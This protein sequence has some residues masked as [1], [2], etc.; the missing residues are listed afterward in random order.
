MASSAIDDPY[1]NSGG[2]MDGNIGDRLIESGMYTTVKIVN[3]AVGGTLL[4][5]WLSTAPNNCYYPKHNDDHFTYTNYRLYERIQFAVNTANTLGFSFTHVILNIGESN[6]GAGTSSADYSRYLTQFRDDLRNLGVNAPIFISKTSYLPGTSAGNMSNITTAQ[7][8]IINS[9]NDVFAGP[10]TDSRDSSYRWDNVHFNDQGLN[11]LGQLWGY[12]LITPSKTFLTTSSS[13]TASGLKRSI[14]SELGLGDYNQIS[15]N[16]YAVGDLIGKY[17]GIDL[18]SAHGKTSPYNISLTLTSN[19]L[20]F[21]LATWAAANGWNRNSKIKATITINSDVYVWSDNISTPAFS[22]GS[23][24]D[25]SE[26]TIIN[27]GYIIGRGANGGNSANYPTI[28]KAGTA[29]QSISSYGYYNFITIYNYGYIAGGGGGGAGG[30]FEWYGGGGGAGGG[31]GGD[32]YNRVGTNSLGGAGGGVGLS[33]SNGNKIVLNDALAVLISGGG[34]GRILPGAGASSTTLTSDGSFNSANASAAGRGG[35]AG[36][37]G[38]IS[39]SNVSAGV[40]ATS[41]TGGSDGNAGIEGPYPG[42]FTGVIRQAGA[43]GGW[44]ASGSYTRYGFNGGSSVING[45]AGGYC[46]YGVNALL[47]WMETGTR[48]GYILS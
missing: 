15:F 11:E 37:S 29:L 10:D 16:D 43:G 45:G 27:H 42:A 2:N 17:T 1:G 47:T 9:Y 3:V 4:D 34:G 25:R 23:L 26:I 48:Y 39:F 28:E 31:K 20:E 46:F 7:Q 30:D 33:G 32:G 6:A 35:G 8:N 36:G 41:S 22:T 13:Y 12:S 24:P 14:S 19:T 18:N 44:G 38:A 5:W 21:N 40:T